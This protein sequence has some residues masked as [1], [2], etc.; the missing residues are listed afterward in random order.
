MSL[1]LFFQ[2]SSTESKFYIRNIHTKIIRTVYG[3][4]VVH[5]SNN[6]YDT[7]FL[8]LFISLTK[9]ENATKNA[10]EPDCDWL[11]EPELLVYCFCLVECHSEIFFFFFCSRRKS[12]KVTGCLTSVCA[13][14]LFWSSVRRLVTRNPLKWETNNRRPVWIKVLE[15]SAPLNILHNVRVINMLIK[16]AWR[17]RERGRVGVLSRRS[18][19]D[20]LFI[21]FNKTLS[22]TNTNAARLRERFVVCRVDHSISFDSVFA[23]L[24]IWRFFIS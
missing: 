20:K 9:A 15:L 17:E 2:Q 10:T 4:I 21:Y 19:A 12:Y 7:N 23:H 1:S 14:L 3:F 11:I 5:H 16:L 8:L 18:G 13:F 24:H 6:L 22:T